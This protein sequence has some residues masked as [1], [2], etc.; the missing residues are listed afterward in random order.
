V[1]VT[2][3]QDAKEKMYTLVKPVAM[4]RGAKLFKGKQTETVEETA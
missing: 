3:L 4:G 1:T 2:V